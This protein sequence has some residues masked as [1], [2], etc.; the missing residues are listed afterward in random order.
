METIKHTIKVS[1]MTVARSLSLYLFTLLLLLPLSC[2][3][4]DYEEL[5]KGNDELTLTVSQSAENL[6]ERYHASDAVSLSWTTGT[7][8]GT[9]RRI[10]YKLE[11][12]PQ[13]G[14]FAQAYV[15]VDSMAQ[16]YTWSASQEN[17]NNILTDKLGGIPG[18]PAS[19]T[20]RVTAIV[21]GEQ[22]QTSEV[23]FTATPYTP[24]TSTLYIIGSATQTGWSADNAEAMTRTDNGIFTWE[25]YLADGT[26]K[27]IT[28]RGQFLP[29]Y[30]LN[31]ADST[32]VLRS[33]DDQPDGQWTISGRH[34][35][36]MTVNLLDSTLA[37]TESEG[38]KPQFDQLYFVGNMTGWGFRA[39]T[40]DPLDNFLF[41][42]GAFFDTGGDFK[43]GTAD[44][45]WENMY[46]AAVA[47]APYTDT[48]MEL[49]S[50]FDPDN[51]WYLQ[52]SETGKA[53]KICVDIRKGNEKMMMREFTPYPMIYLVGDATPN[54]WDLG[55]ATAMTATDSPY[56]FT[57]TGSLRAGEL[58]F[59]C[60]RQ[61]DWNGAWFLCA[62]GND[63]EPT[64]A[65]E[66][67]LFVDKSDDNF[68]NQYPE[69]NIGD[70]D[71]KWKITSSGTYTITLN[72]LDETVSIVKQ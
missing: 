20:A 57:W 58:K 40:Q 2:T 70:V 13:G 63:V 56:I 6:S 39:M 17:L 30:N 64:G 72:Q 62:S 65:T 36:M 19:V 66:H 69:V 22:P 37:M 48:R 16:V 67:A 9:G 61:S 21:E 25:G 29:S 55:N 11:L 53:Y 44:G 4:Q 59:S 24:V 23:S 49:I 12:A 35:Y 46:K 71:Q 7:N 42:Y 8:Y 52:D 15:A 31:L 3:D 32:V 43:F 34:Y 47:N 1:A 45:S 28:T 50:G 51:K 26:F 41:R 60:D 14:S 33:S 68:K 10:H 38:V 18:Q 5:D 54:G 27:F